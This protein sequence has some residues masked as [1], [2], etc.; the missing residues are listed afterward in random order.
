MRF[1][2]V[3]EASGERFVFGPLAAQHIADEFHEKLIPKLQVVI[4][5]RSADRL[6]ERPV[7][8]LR[9]RSPSCCVEMCGVAAVDCPLQVNTPMRCLHL[10]PGIG[11]CI[12]IEKAGLVV[13]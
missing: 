13:D 2:N 4:E 5:T 11:R 6:S 1:A 10:V 8:P 9:T 7:A 3:A 12:G